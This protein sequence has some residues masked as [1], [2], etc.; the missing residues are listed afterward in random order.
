MKVPLARVASISRANRDVGPPARATEDV[1]TLANGDTL[2]GIVAG[3]TASTISIQPSG[4]AATD[5][6]LESIAAVHFAALAGAG[7]PTPQ[8]SARA[9]RVTLGDS[10]TIAAPSIQLAGDQL[11]LTLADKSARKVPLAGV[12]SIEQVNGPV[13]WL[14]SKAPV[15]NVQT[16][17]LDRPAP[18]RMNQ[19]VLGEPIRFGGR[20]YERGIGVHAYA[21]LAW[22]LDASRYKAFRT[23]YAL[24]GQLPYANVTVRIKLD[25][26]VAHEVKDFRAGAL[27]PL[28]VLDTKGAKRITL[29]VDWGDTY[30]VQDRFNW[31][32]PALL[33]EKPP[34][35]EPPRPVVKPAPT[36]S[37]TPTPT[38]ATSPATQP[39][40][41]RAAE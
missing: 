7:N 28:V 38:P 35:P 36:T 4:A 13:V 16:P 2:R 30:D 31:I 6:P 39:A 18:A 10:T 3:I 29:E 26:R 41:T 22:E 23:Q 20:T 27:A 1:V 21:R 37:T 24:D 17:F 8:G 9:F 15:E 5:V 32:E 12:V 33:K 19:T 25:D 34:P 40:A 11:T 14:S